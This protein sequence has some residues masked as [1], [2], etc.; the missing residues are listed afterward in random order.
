MLIIAKSMGGLSFGALVTVYGESLQTLSQEQDFYYYLND[1][2]FRMAGARYLIWQEEGQY[3]SALRVEPYRDGFLLNGLE[4][5]P[6]HRGKGYAAALIRAT[7]DY[8]RKQ[9]TACLYSH[10]EKKN[11]PSLMVHRKCGFE[12][13]SDRAVFLDGS[14]DCRSVTLFYKF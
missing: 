7:Q 10:V 6:E 4:T 12:V 13:L 5:A 1:C 11:T 2:F 9:G 8:L 3:L 14:A